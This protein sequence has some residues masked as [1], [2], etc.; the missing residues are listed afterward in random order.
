MQPLRDVFGEL[1][2]IEPVRR[3]LV[4]MVTGLD[5][6]YD[7][8][9]GD[10]PLLGRRLPDQDLLIGD[11]KTSTHELMTAGRP[12]LLD[13][14]DDATLREAAT[15]WSDR[16]DIVTATPHDPSV[17][18]ANLLVRPDGYIAWAATGDDQRVTLTEALTRWFG[19]PRVLSR[20]TTPTT[21]VRQ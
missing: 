11:R 9:T 20:S 3:L 19:A 14:G 8:G 4:G 7:V 10:H 12:L 16:V 17:P 21:G 5:I 18:A 1:A 13:M 2:G 15:G 6:R